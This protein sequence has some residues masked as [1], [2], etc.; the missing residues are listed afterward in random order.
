MSKDSRQTE[1]LHNGYNVSQKPGQIGSK[2]KGEIPHSALRIGLSIK[3]SYG[4]VHGVTR[5]RGKIRKAPSAERT[6]VQRDEPIGF[7]R[8]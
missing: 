1:W 6:V 8:R 2:L 4:P 5:S 7:G 3:M